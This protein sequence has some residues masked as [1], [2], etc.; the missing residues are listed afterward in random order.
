MPDV[1]LTK[2]EF[3]PKRDLDELEK[4][5]IDVLKDFEKKHKGIFTYAEVEIIKKGQGTE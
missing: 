5:I 1:S 2:V 4:K 3:L